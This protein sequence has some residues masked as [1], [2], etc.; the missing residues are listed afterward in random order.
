MKNYLLFATLLFYC[1]LFSSYLTQDEIDT[2]YKEGFFV[3][4]NA[5]TEKDLGLIDQKSSLLLD[6]I[7]SELD[8][9]IYPF[10]DH[11]QKIY[12][13]GAQI[14]FAKE[15]GKPPSIRRFVGCESLEPDFQKVLSSKKMKETFFALLNTDAIEQLVSQYHPKSSR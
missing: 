13:E 6:R 2:F 8:K 4:R 1:S 14:V 10:S 12:I 5:L 15:Q 9:E 3:K 11:D 7:L